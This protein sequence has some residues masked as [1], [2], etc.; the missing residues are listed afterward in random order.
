MVIVEAAQ[1]PIVLNE[2][3]LFEKLNVKTDKIKSIIKDITSGNIRIKDK[4]DEE[5]I[6]EFI[7]DNKDKL[8]SLY[9]ALNID[10]EKY[11]YKKDGLISL[12]SELVAISLS[13]TAIFVPTALLIG[14]V[15]IPVE[16][17]TLLLAVL[18][19]I[20]SIVKFVNMI[21]NT[22]AINEANGALMKVKRNMAKIDINKFKNN[23][24]TEEYNKLMDE[25]DNSLKNNKK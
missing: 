24:L 9:K 18:S 22:K 25:I 11:D 19:L 20:Y 2:F 5:E 13:V 10:M 3:A 23:K 8:E 1:S 12:L 17:I 16:F 4:D 6:K 14:S 15:I 7:E 21:S